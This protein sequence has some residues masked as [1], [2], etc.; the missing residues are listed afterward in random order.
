MKYTDVIAVCD[1]DLGYTNQVKHELPLTDDVPTSQPYFC[2]TPTQFEEV[3]EHISRLLK[4]GVIQESSS[5]YASPVV[6]VFKADGSLRLCMDYRRLN[7]KT[8]CDAFPL[9]NIDK[10][11]DALSGAQVFSTIDLASSYHQVAIHEKDRHKMAFIT[12]FGLYKYRCMPFRLCNAPA[13][14][15]HLMQAIMSNLVFQIV[16]IYLDDLLVYSSTFRDHLV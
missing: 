5:S 4:K 11:L 7:S 2:I 3:R 14:F 12:P 1:E 13:M 10:S 6:L 9:P 8:K 15:Q 16:L